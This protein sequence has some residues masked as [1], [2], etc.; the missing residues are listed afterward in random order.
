MN[1]GRGKTPVFKKFRSPSQVTPPTPT[2][3]RAK[4]TQAVTPMT[5]AMRGAPSRSCSTGP[6]IQR[7]Q[8]GKFEMCYCPQS[9][10][11]KE[12]VS[13]T[14]KK[15]TRPA[16]ICN[17][18]APVP[19]PVVE[20]TVVKKDIYEP[21]EILALKDSCPVG[22][23]ITTPGMLVYLRLFKEDRKNPF[24]KGKK[25]GTKK[26][27]EHNK[28]RFI[29]HARARHAGVFDEASVEAKCA[30]MRVALNRLSERNMSEVIERI[31]G[32]KLPDD[33]VINLILERATADCDFPERNPQ[34]GSL[35]D[36]VLIMCEPPYPRSFSDHFVE[37]AYKHAMEMSRDTSQAVG[38]LQNMA[39]WFAVLYAGGVISL[40]QYDDFMTSVTE[41]QET[42]KA[43]ETL[44]T[45]LFVGGKS[46]SV[47]KKGRTVCDKFFQFLRDHQIMVGQI[48][49]LVSDLF[50]LKESGWKFES[51]TSKPQ[52]KLHIVKN[53]KATETYDL[54]TVDTLEQKFQNND[55]NPIRGKS[56]HNVISVCFRQLSKHLNYSY[57]FCTFCGSIIAEMKPPYGE[58]LK[59]LTQEQAKY[60][61]IVI[62]EDNPMLW[63]MVIQ[64]YASLFT[65]HLITFR[66]IINLYKRMP[67]EQKPSQI[68]F[69][70]KV[71]SITGVPIAQVRE[72]LREFDDSKEIIDDLIFLCDPINGTDTVKD[73]LH[74]GVL[75]RDLIEQS[76]ETDPPQ[77][78]SVLDA[79]A[80][81]I[82]ELKEFRETLERVASV[83]VE[84]EIVSVI[85]GLFA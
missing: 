39:T 85:R 20:K 37:L 48:R 21:S 76:F 64:L 17:T 79:A 69:I 59:I 82:T 23:P 50:V 3:E 61:D 13:I 15:P 6:V 77:F 40:E 55:T 22:E 72:S 33:V 65:A 47:D 36:L 7:S 56:H 78:K 75:I 66:D 44:R 29:G 63:S 38:C 62:D 74:A 28:E 67:K 5:I 9:S 80:T 60:V 52:K 45:S 54:E 41:N 32:L 70:R 42:A 31:R 46:L 35:L 24:A 18:S 14:I 12:I 1:R 16:I 11:S 43:V 30:S 73:E 2:I 26:L 68:L 58:L 71:G 84:D 49:W 4:T 83:M 53:A 27:L 19:E 51:I 81:E 10:V 34:L 25:R 57:E 8:T